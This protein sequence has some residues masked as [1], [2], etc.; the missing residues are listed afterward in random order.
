MTGTSLTES[1]LDPADAV[2]T[3]VVPAG[4]PWLHPLDAGQTLR[5]LDL[6]GNQAADTLF[7][8]SPCSVPI[9]NRP[10]GAR[11]MRAS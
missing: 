10:C 2:Y 5:I 8:R 11:R 9:D 6:E 3:T 1:P 4:E 7:E